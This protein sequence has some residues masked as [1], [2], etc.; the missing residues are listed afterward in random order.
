MLKK[1]KKVSCMNVKNGGE[2]HT[3]H[4]LLVR[5]FLEECVML[6]WAVKVV[7]HKVEAREELFLGA[8]SIVGNSRVL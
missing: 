4:E 1:R 7:E 3:L 6:N 8:T 2:T 5:V